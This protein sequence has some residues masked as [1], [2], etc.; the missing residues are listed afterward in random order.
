MIKEINPLKE[1]KRGATAEFD[2]TIDKMITAAEEFEVEE[3][4][5]SELPVLAE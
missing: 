1:A 3:V 2:T 5:T 4:D